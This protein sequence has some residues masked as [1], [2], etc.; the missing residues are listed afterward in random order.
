VKGPVAQYDVAAG[1]LA[2]LGVKPGDM[3]AVLLP[4]SLDFVCV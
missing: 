1:F 4:N 3:V 2:G